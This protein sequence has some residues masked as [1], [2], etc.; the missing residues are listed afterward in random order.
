MTHS[1]SN[2]FA[3]GRPRVVDPLGKEA[4][5]VV[6]LRISSKQ[7]KKLEVEANKRGVSLSTIFREIL[8]QAS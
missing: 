7:R 3:M 6:T 8:D 1:R 5:Q 2:V 4:G